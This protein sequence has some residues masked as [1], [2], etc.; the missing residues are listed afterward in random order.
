VERGKWKVE[1]EKWKV[2]S[3]KWKVEINL[4]L[5]L[6]NWKDLLHFAGILKILFLF[7]PI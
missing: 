4:F 7:S 1:R 5:N 6:E 3:G 2:E